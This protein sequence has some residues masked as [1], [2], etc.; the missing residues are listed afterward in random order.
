M[1]NVN[2]FF[3]INFARVALNPFCLLAAFQRIEIQKR[4]ILL[5]LLT[6]W[7]LRS[8]SVHF[9]KDKKLCV[10]PGARAKNCII[11]FASNTHILN[12][13]ILTLSNEKSCLSRIRLSSDSWSAMNEKR[14]FVMAVEHTFSTYTKIIESVSVHSRER[15]S[16][17]TFLH[18]ILF[19]MSY[20]YNQL[21]FTSLSMYARVFNIDLELL[22]C[23]L[24]LFENVK[25]FGKAC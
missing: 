7:D 4:S 9:R 15:I 24:W 19:A 16:F 13:H 6:L 17:S 2:P 23:H 14:I 25:G 12:F 18:W 11:M 21:A 5:S 8:S 1:N 22:F 10:L 20:R 3:I